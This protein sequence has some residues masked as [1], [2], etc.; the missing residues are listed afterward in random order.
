M[1][2]FWERGYE[3]TSMLDLT[4]AMGIASAS[5]YAAFGSKEALFREAVALNAAT[6]GLPPRMAL[7]ERV[8]AYDAIR[9]MLQAVADTITIPNSPR[10]CMLVLAAPTGALENHPVREFL[11]GARKAQFND[12]RDRLTKGVADGDLSLS[13]GTVDGMARFY[14][15][16][17]H[18]LS[19]QA[20]DGA[21]RED[22]ELVIDCAM[23]AWAS[24]A[25]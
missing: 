12:I 14:T 23:A 20:R 19:V 21:S 6:Q 9:A 4:E 5:I 2:L 24:L 16:V 11:A 17:M 18:G 22:L 1:D 25:A 15:T 10:G 7:R 13:K 3:G 8:T